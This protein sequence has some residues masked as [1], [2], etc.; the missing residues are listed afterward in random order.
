MNI[1]K[2]FHTV[3]IW[4]VNKTFYAVKDRKKCWC[5]PTPFTQTECYP[6]QVKKMH[7]N[8]HIQKLQKNAMVGYLLWFRI[9]LRSP[10]QRWVIM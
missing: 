1:K 2:Q 7:K 3:C 8:T 6:A 4:T 9:K 10:L 5:A